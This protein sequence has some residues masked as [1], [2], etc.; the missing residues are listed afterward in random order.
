MDDQNAKYLNDR[1]FYLGFGEKLSAELEKNMKAGKEQFQL[2]VQGEFTKGD[3]K[4]VVDYTIDFSK[5]KESDMYFLN[6]YQATLKNDD[7]EKERSQTFYINKGSGV[8][9]KEAYNLLEGRAVHKKLTN[10]EGEPYEA[11]LQ[12]QEKKEDNGHHKVQQFHSA[13]GYDLE[14]SLAK[15]P[16][17]ELGDPDQKERLI[18]SLEKGNLQQV[19]YTRNEK[20]EKMLLEANPKDRNVIVYDAQMV[21]QFQGIKEHQGEKTGVSKSQDDNS[22][23]KKKSDR[24]EVLDEPD[25]KEKKAKGRKMS[26]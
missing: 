8:T 24:K 11:W 26:V 18:K 10:R 9:A 1:L 16:I 19:T 14:K 15:H 6:K 12:L 25:A 21:K 7:P 4:K 23:E 17:K 22:S 2:P 3:Q 20:E 13:Y 5:S